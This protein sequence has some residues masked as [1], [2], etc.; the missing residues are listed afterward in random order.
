MWFCL[1]RL[2]FGLSLIAAASAVLLATDGNRSR[3]GSLPRIAI[4]DYAATPVFED[5]LRGML[6]GLSAAGYRDGQTIRISFYNA[7]G[8]MATS[9]AIAREIIAGRFDLVLTSGTQGL[10]AVANANKA[11]RTRHVFG[12]VTDPFVA[13]VGL[14]P[15][16]PLH[17]PRYLVGSGLF[18]PVT[19]SFRIARQMLPD[20]KTLGVAWNPAEANSRRFVEEART[21]CRELGLTLLE[22]QVENSAAVREAIQ[23]LIGREIQAVWVGGDSTVESALETVVKTARQARLPVF[24]CVPSHPELGTLFDQG[25]DFYQA[26]RLTGELAAQVLQGAD[27]AQIPILDA[28]QLVRHRLL[29]NTKA[30]KGL[31]EPWRVPDDLLRQAD[32]VVDDHGV[33]N[34]TPE[35]R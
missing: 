30:L 29:I 15:A 32:T 13:G 4:L 2:S 24:S 26:G 6:D 21:A 27:L 11:G 34:K 3:E 28:A 18:F 16:N 35:E 9:N 10:Q 22:A 8:E 7:Q 25:F 14:D 31:R 5:N 1:K 17:H 23:S 12:L 33:H 20:L 19:E